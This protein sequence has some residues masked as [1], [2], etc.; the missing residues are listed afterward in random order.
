MKLLLKL[1]LL[2]ALRLLNSFH[3][4]YKL[5]AL[6]LLLLH[7]VTIFGK[8]EKHSSVDYFPFPQ[9]IQSYNVRLDSITGEHVRTGLLEMIGG[10]PSYDEL[11]R[12]KKR[13]SLQEV[14]RTLQCVSYDHDFDVRGSVSFSRL[15]PPSRKMAEVIC[16]WLETKCSPWEECHKLAQSFKS[17]QY[18]KDMLHFTGFAY[19]IKLYRFIGGKLYLDWPWGIDRITERGNKP[20]IHT[21]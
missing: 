2:I 6:L 13:Y 4:V 12:N 8:H 3:G 20:H 9:S 17:G 11:L 16:A 19:W 18:N 15:A 10:V 14:K 5:H 7:A 1:D 21:Y